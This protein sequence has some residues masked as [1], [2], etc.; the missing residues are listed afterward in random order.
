MAPKY[1]KKYGKDHA[2]QKSVGTL[3]RDICE[4]IRISGDYRAYLDEEFFWGAWGDV[5]DM[6]H[7]D[8]DFRRDVG[9]LVKFAYLIGRGL[10][11]KYD[12]IVRSDEDFKEKKKRIEQLLLTED[13][14]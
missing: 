10:I 9:S 12:D 5:I 7:T 8:P 11:D 3:A 4:R 13:P 6:D 2:G 14:K 1:P